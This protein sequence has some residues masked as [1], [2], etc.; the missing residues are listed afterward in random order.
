MKKLSVLLLVLSVF[1]LSMLAPALAE[2][3]I[4]QGS[5]YVKTDNGKA[6]RF[7]AKPS[8]SAEVLTELPYGT[9]V[10]VTSWDGT[11]ARV[12]YNSA[13]G[14]V[15][16]KYLVVA[17]PEPY[18]VVVAERAEAAAEKEKE[19]EEKAAE[20]ER[21]KEEKAAELERMKEL[22]AANNKLDH[23]KVKTISAYDVTVRVGVV[24]LTVNLYNKPDLTSKVL[25]TYEDG[26]RLVVYATNKDWAQVYNGRTDNLGYMLLT[27]LEAD[28]VED[29]LLDDDE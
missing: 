16:Q 28:I 26:E 23:S 20:K 18:E 3:E 17:R 25:E 4:R 5:M 6:L 1:L 2:N 15:V 8:T 11:W 10:Y 22:A 27:D 24:D 21:E 9:K 19:K 14:Y 7:R 12:T 13:K 29:E